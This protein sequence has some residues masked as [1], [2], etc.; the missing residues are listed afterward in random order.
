MHRKLIAI[1]FGE[2]T[3]KAQEA[4]EHSIPIHIADATQLDVSVDGKNTISK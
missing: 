4:K 3:Q 2:D 1:L